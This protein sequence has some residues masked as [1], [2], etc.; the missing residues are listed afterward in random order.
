MRNNIAGIV[1]SLPEADCAEISKLSEE[2]RVCIAAG[3]FDWIG[4]LA[5][6]VFAQAVNKGAE[7]GSYE[8]ILDHAVRALAEYPS[9]ESL[10]TLLRIPSTLGSSKV[11]RDRGE[12]RLASL[13]AHGQHAEHIERVL[14]D[15]SSES[16]HSQNFLACLI[17]ELVLSS[18]VIEQYPKVISFAERLISERHPLGVLPLRLLPEEEVLRRPP[19]AAPDWTWAVPPGSTTVNLPQELL[20]GSDHELDIE[21]AETSVPESANAM[22][23]AVNHWRTQSNGRV[24]AQDF[25]TADPIAREQFPDI[26]KQLPLAPWNF[27]PSQARLYPST[28][29]LTLRTLLSAATLGPAYGPGLY[30]AYGRLATWQSLGGLTGCPADTPVTHIAEVA[31]G[32]YWFRTD[33]KS[34]WFYEVAWD[35]SVAVLRPGGQEIAFL[36]ATDTD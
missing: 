26:F 14:F 33:I 19:D 17:Q 22:A 2:I 24:V 20:P 31:R 28:L 9:V 21:I 11:E 16:A 5:T 34:A 36:A 18:V 30:G 6:A 7:T 23:A 10:Q 1:A 25:W 13:V 15:T 27:E 35:L 8:L 12:R 4:E 29:D 32:A 3:R